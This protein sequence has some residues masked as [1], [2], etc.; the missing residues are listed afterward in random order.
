MRTLL[1]ALAIMGAFFMAPGAMAED[2]KPA[3]SQGQ[4]DSLTQAA[5]TILTQNILGS[6]DNL[7]K[8]GVKI[9]RDDFILALSSSLAGGNTGFTAE[10]ADKYIGDYIESLRPNRPDTV[11]MAGEIAFI[12]KAAAIEGAQTLPSGLVF[13]VITEGEGVHPTVQDQV[14]VNYTGRLSN[15]DIFDQTD[16]QPAT[17]D[18]TRVIPGFT[19]GLLLMK[20]GGTYRLTI[21]ANLAYGTKGIPGIIPG[22]SAL[23]FTVTLEGVQLPASE[24][25]TAP[26]K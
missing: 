8:L 11:P 16:D 15:G 9:N 13:Q 21:P 18:V 17:F 20:P 2:A 5:A 24:N 25:G 1:T 22:N 19:E 12:K 3:M 23:E 4:T 6:L 10:T 7:N 26:S 14:I